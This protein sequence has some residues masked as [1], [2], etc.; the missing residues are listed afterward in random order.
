MRK[1][2]GSSAGLNFVNDGTTKESITPWLT[3]RSKAAALKNTLEM[4]ELLYGNNYAANLPNSPF[5]QSF[6]QQFPS[7]VRA[8]VIKNTVDSQLAAKTTE[9]LNRTGFVGDQA[10]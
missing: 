1:S 7:Y 10:F 6:K 4:I 9:M 3:D 8:N 5:Y 2:Y